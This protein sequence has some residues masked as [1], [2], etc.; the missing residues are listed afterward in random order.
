MDSNG[1]RDVRCKWP[2]GR[3]G[4]SGHW[5]V[6]NAQDD[7]IF[8]GQDDCHN[9]ASF[10]AIIIQARAKHPELADK[11]TLHD[12]WGEEDASD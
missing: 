4:A 1:V 12:T 6:C 8:C 2:H 11:L 7:R 10:E 3:H 9:T 5:A